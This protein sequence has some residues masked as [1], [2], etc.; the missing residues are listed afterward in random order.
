MRGE[1]RDGRA[2]DELPPIERAAGR[3]AGRY[4]R[5]SRRRNRSRYDCGFVRFT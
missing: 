1:A 4:L 2:V 3:A 5:M